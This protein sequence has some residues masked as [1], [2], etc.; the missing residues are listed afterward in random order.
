MI[1]GFLADP[2]EQYPKY[3]GKSPFFLKYPFALPC[4][5]GAL[6]PIIGIIVGVLFLQEVG[7]RSL[8]SRLLP[9]LT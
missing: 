6:F 5:V 3:F 4:F 8:K 1:G 2:A 9:W 7:L